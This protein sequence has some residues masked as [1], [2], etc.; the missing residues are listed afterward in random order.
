MDKLIQIW[1]AKDLRKKIIFVLLMLVVFRLAASVPIPGVNTEAL[2]ELFASSQVLGMMNLF[3]GGGM[4]TF[5][6]V[7]M[8]VMP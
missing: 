5:S 8:G 4:Q 2:R 1:K 7:M 6:V 3:S